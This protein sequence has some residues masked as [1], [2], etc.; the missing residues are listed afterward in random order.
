VA[1]PTIPTV[2][3]SRVLFQLALSPAGTHTSPSLT[4]LANNAGDLLIAICIIYDGNSTNAE[5]SAWGGGFTE[6]KDQA[7]TATMGIGCAYKFSDGTE[8]GTFTVTTADTSTND[9][10]FIL[11]SIPGAHATTPPEAGTMA[12]GTGAADPGAF[13]PAGWDAEDTLWIAVGGSGETSGTGSYTGLASAPANYTDYADSGISADVVGGVEG[14]V[15]FRQLNAASEDVGAFTGDTSNARDSALVIAVRPAPVATGAYPAAV[16]ADGAI[17]YWRL[18]EPSGTN[19][20]DEIGAN[21]GTY[22]NTPAL[23]QV[24]ALI[25]DADTAVLFDPAQSEYVTVADHATLDQGDGPLSWECWYKRTT[26]TG[27]AGTLISKGTSAPIL[28]LLDPPQQAFWYSRGDSSAVTANDPVDTNWH[29][30]VGTKSAADAW[31]IYI[32]GRDVTIPNLSPSTVS[33]ATALEIGRDASSADTY[34][35]GSIDEVALYN[36]VLTPTQIWNHFQLGRPRVPRS[37]Q[38]PQILP[39]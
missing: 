29:H 7:G 34:F 10:C 37:R 8:T 21:D 24:G 12:T 36:A 38:Y 14:A 3:A 17:A 23:A 39:H 9:S 5:F 20:N 28:Q 16:I 4:T 19:A 30:I 15:A 35:A 11:L 31:L 18:G 6:F 13:N 26:A 33:T 25:G 22:T 1:F 27:S 32:D 2:A